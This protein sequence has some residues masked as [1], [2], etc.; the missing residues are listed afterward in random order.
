MVQRLSKEER[1]N[2]IKEGAKKAFISKG[3]KDATMEDIVRYSNTSVGGIYHHYNNKAEILYDLMA[4]GNAQRKEIIYQ[5]IKE[6]DLPL[7]ENDCSS[8]S[9]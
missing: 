7:N 1:K 3:Y 5:T 8:H 4:D 2:L 6:Y 9:R